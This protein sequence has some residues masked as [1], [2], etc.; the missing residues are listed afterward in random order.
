MPTVSNCIEIRKENTARN[1]TKINLI[2]FNVRI[3]AI[4]RTSN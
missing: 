3:S 2:L 4:E 1:M